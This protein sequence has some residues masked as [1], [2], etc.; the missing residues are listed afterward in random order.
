MSGII[1]YAVYTNKNIPFNFRR[2]QVGK[3]DN[4]RKGIVVEV[5]EIHLMQVVVAT[6]DVGQLNELAGPPGN[7]IINPTDRFFDSCKLEVRI[8]GM[9]RDERL[10]FGQEIF[11]K[12]SF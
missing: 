1:L 7:N 3:G 2:L 4:I 10:I 5:F 6:E 8:F 12:R 11:Q 9:K